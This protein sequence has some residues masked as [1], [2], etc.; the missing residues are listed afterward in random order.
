MRQSN[1]IEI[2]LDMDADKG[3]DVNEQVYNGNVEVAPVRESYSVC[4]HQMHKLKIKIGALSEAAQLKYLN[5]WPSLNPYR[6]DFGTCDQVQA[7]MAQAFCE[8]DLYFYEFIQRYKLYLASRVGQAGFGPVT[9]VRPSQKVN[10][11]KQRGYTFIPLMLLFAAVLWTCYYWAEWHT[12]S[13][14]SLLVSLWFLPLVSI[15]GGLK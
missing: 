6:P 2:F 14:V 12:L 3:S 7:V 11:G 9:V 10:P 8:S 15:R 13:K 4:L 1:W 5:N